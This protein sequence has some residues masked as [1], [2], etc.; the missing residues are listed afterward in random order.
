MPAIDY[1]VNVFDQ[2]GLTA[3]ARS[4]E[5][6]VPFLVG[7]APGT[8]TAAANEPVAVRTYSDYEAAFGEPADGD[9]NAYTLAAA[10]RVLFD[11]YRVAPAIFV[12]VYDADVGV[13]DG[14][15]ANVDAAD[16]VGSD[17]GAGTRTGLETAN[18][19]FTRLALVPTLFL[20]PGYSTEQAVRDKLTAL[21]EAH[22]G[23]FRGLALLDLAGSS[24]GAGVAAK[25]AAG[26]GG[27]ALDDPY[28]VACFPHVRPLGAEGGEPVYVA[29]PMSVHLAGAIAREAADR[30]GIPYRSPSNTPLLGAGLCDEAGDPVTLVDADVVALRDAGV[31]TAERFGPGGFKFA[32]NRTSAFLA[33][34]ATAESAEAEARDSFVPGRLVANYLAN[35]LVL[36]TRALADGPITRAQADRVADAAGRVGN[37]LVAEGASLGF[38]VAFLPADNDP[39]QLSSGH[40]VYRVTFLPPP[41]MER[42]DFLLDVELS[43]FGALFA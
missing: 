7:T 35:K 1:D 39:A 25:A 18:E 17:D 24:A 2:A 10:A 16:V 8:G 33:G 3:P 4:V 5:G 23:K 14:D 36:D 32:G 22:N 30:G 9:T 11:T 28:A 34:E 6:V 26:P 12:N 38:D 13:H 19:A 41:P 43:Y 27:A 31:V 20:A 15:V 40:V 42:I 21:A 29:D 37:A